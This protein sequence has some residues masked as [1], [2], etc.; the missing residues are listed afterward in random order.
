MRHVDADVV[1][2][3]IAAEVLGSAASEHLGGVTLH[4]H[5]HDAV[6]RLRRMLEEH[7]GALLADDV[8]LGK[9]YAALAVAQGHGGVVVI[10]P[11]G[12]REHWLTCAQRAGV[13]IAFHSMESLSQCGAPG[14]DPD[15][16]VID[17][18]HHFRTVRTRRFSAARALC[19]RAQ[20]L[21]LSATPVQNRDTDLRAVLSLFLGAR[22][23]ALSDEE[24]ARLVVRRGAED[25]GE[26][27]TRLPG[28][29]P[30]RWLP[31]ID[32]VDCLDRI[33]GLPDAVP[34]VDGKD[35]GALVSFTLVR[36]WAS[37]R[38]ALAAALRR[39]IA[40]GLAMMDALGAGRIPS[41]A[42]LASW[43][44]VDDAQQLFFPELV[45][46]AASEAA[47]LLTHVDRHVEGARALLDWLV[48]APDPDSA[49]AH[50]LRSLLD[51]HP[52]ERV[53]AFSEYAD[54]VAALFRLVVPS[55]QVAMLTHGGG[56]LVS[57]PISRAEILERFAAGSR[58]RTHLRERIDLLLTTD[59]L[60]EG[61]NLPDASVVV[62]L[63]LAW[64]PA[65]LEQRVGRL[66][67]IDSTH[68]SIA[69]YVMPTPAPAERL[70]SVERRLRAKRAI[71]HRTIGT[72]GTILP[73]DD[74]SG[75]P[76]PAIRATERI[77][78][79]LRSWRRAAGHRPR[80]V[81]AGVRASERGGIACVRV[82]GAVTLLAI[83]DGRVSEET[84]EV[85]RL[86]AGAGGETA[87]ID[88]GL[89][90]ETHRL[91]E[92]FLVR[93]QVSGVVDVTAMHVARARR[94]LLQRADS[95]ARGASREQ[96]PR[97]APLL[98]AVRAAA[99]S[100]LSA[101][102]E[103]ALHE[104]TEAALPDDAWL[105]A[106]EEFAAVHANRSPLPSV[107]VLAL[108]ILRPG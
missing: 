37:S 48:T 78:S 46:A 83:G 97:L 47:Q 90:D 89:V 103:R 40:R 101:G 77:A 59:V 98:H 55:T 88:A 93:R 72:A 41:R 56:R 102:A 44:H 106:I 36:Q 84:A 27:G 53:I 107:E 60:S 21:L 76:P 33:L 104:L 65:R 95:I 80:G 85:E 87:S 32:D 91:V 5:Q 67:R 26:P 58:A 24:L 2:A 19:A 34:P 52:G 29:D 30:P 42:E 81:V 94:A 23:R 3:V 45:R 69:V 57:G 4:A 74:A 16:V 70:L 13:R 39:R 99:T 108:L 96:R 35:G 31:R 11:A 62:H 28:V 18:A 51:R 10:G 92:H 22:A 38:A 68:R 82:G 86:C 17:E 66:R 6:G 15:L 25:L 43:C 105:R 20:V 61:V 14:V 79:L 64:N 49:R 71:A 12:V 63:D 73:G 8:G 100:S 9:T 50:A 7:G 1:R 54:T 75:L